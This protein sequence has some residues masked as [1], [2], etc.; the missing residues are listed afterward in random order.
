[1]KLKYIIP[2][3]FSLLLINTAVVADD[4]DDDDFWNSENCVASKWFDPDGNNISIEDKFGP[5][6]MAVTRCL[7]KTKKIK[8]VYQINAECKN[9]ECT[10]AYA[11]GNIINHIIDLTIT[12]GISS[13]KFEIVAIVQ[14]AGWKLVLDNNAEN[15]HA[16]NNRFQT[17]MEDLVALDSVKVLLCQ[18][19]ANGKGI[20]KANMI[21]GIGFVPAGVSAIADLQRLKYSYIQ[22]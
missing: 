20:V 7:A 5:G 1:M 17:A 6:T 18:N 2:M 8:V 3:F 10:A 9:A 15:K 22:P 14:G 16:A 13:D 11:I 12:H 21:D 19:T 4:D